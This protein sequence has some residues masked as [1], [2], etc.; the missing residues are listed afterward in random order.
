MVLEV[1]WYPL[2]IEISQ[3]LTRLPDASDQGNNEFESFWVFS[4]QL[5]NIFLAN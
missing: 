3:R 2:Q 5:L 1:S 4:A